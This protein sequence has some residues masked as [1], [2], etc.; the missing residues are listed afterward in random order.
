MST[1]RRQ[2][3]SLHDRVQRGI[4]IEAFREVLRLRGVTRPRQRQRCQT[5]DISS[6]HQRQHSQRVLPCSTG[7]AELRF[8]QSSITCHSAAVSLASTRRADSTARRE[9]SRAVS[10]RP[11]Y[12]SVSDCAESSQSSSPARP[13]VQTN[14]CRIV[15]WLPLGLTCRR[16]VVGRDGNLPFA[17]EGARSACCMVAVTRSRVT[18]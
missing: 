9:K 15:C 11:E 7:I 6:S 3:V 1:N 8:P 4:L 17:A 12:A 5:P 16:H 2:P 13:A 14:C 18:R 10:S